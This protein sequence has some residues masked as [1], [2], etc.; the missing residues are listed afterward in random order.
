M[1]QDGATPDI[2]EN[3]ARLWGTHPKQLA[4]PGN[5]GKTL[6]ETDGNYHAGKHIHGKYNDTRIYQILRNEKKKGINS[7]RILSDITRRMEKGHWKKLLR[8]R[9]IMKITETP[10]LQSQILTLKD[11]FDQYTTM[12]R[13]TLEACKLQV[14][15]WRLSLGKSLEL[16]PFELIIP[17]ILNTKFRAISKPTKSD[18]RSKNLMKYGLDAT[19]KPIL[20][21]GRLDKDIDKFGEIVRF[22]CDDLILNCQIFPVDHKKDRLSS[23]TKIIHQENIQYYITIKPPHNW[24]IRADL[25][26]QDKIH[27]STIMAATWHHQLDYD[28]IY[29]AV[30]NLEKIVVGNHIHWSPL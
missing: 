19:G 30:E 6:A 21:I 11:E 2:A 9:W 23:I 1:A 28:F 24:S 4:K 7:I 22:K 29:N 16:I 14:T 18:L 15:E 17:S 3:G 12:I 20:S 25:I 27:R 5:P 26:K 10:F 13:P 8:M